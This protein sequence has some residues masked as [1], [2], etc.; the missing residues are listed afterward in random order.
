M[1]RGW[2][3]N[4]PQ[5]VMG[6]KQRRGGSSSRQN[7]HTK[8]TP[9]NNTK[10]QKLN[11]SRNNNNIIDSDDTCCI[12]PKMIKIKSMNQRP[13]ISAQSKT[14]DLT[15]IIGECSVC[16]EVG[17]LVPLFKS[18]NHDPQC[19][20]CLRKLYV[21]QA[22][23]DIF[24]Y[25]L[26]CYHPYCKRPIH[27]AQLINHGLVHTNKE[28][29]NHRRLTVLSRAH[30]C[31]KKVAYCPDCDFP[32]VVKNEEIVSCRQCDTKFALLH[33]NIS[34]WQSTIAAIESFGTDNV[35][36]CDSYNSWAHCPNC[37]M[38]I[39]KDGGDDLMFCVCGE[40]K[41]AHVVYPSRS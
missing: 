16:W 36:D 38:I 30:R 17:E 8:R 24:N 14:R 5:D 32:R 4:Q 29:S 6:R 12:M 33:G 1:P 37:K 15:G 3:K 2:L 7:K 26:R 13:Q 11:P 21:K 19:Q 23:K 10:Q 28:L 39:V 41:I 25:P 35:D 18:C 34:T 27:E 9:P 20:S 31:D 40:L 22:Q